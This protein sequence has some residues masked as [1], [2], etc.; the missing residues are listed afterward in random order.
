MLGKRNSSERRGRWGEI[1]PAG[2]D[3]GFE[4][5][6]MGPPRGSG[7]RG[8]GMAMD[9]FQEGRPRAVAVSEMGEGAVVSSLVGV[10]WDG[11]VG[12]RPRG[13]PFET[14]KSPSMGVERLKGLEGTSGARR[15][16][17]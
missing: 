5:G 9:E 3:R 13:R 14:G 12:R 16:E 1:W 17:T 7:E 11:K 6:G 10:G 15:E 4:V 2:R 8:A